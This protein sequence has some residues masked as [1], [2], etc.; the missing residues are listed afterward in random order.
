MDF[1]VPGEAIG[2]AL[3]GILDQKKGNKK[4]HEKKGWKVQGLGGNRGPQQG[5]FGRK[6][7]PGPARPN[8][9][10][11]GGRIEPAEPEPPP[12]HSIGRVGEDAMGR[13]GQFV[14][15]CWLGVLVRR[16]WCGA[17]G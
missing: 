8:P 4:K 14:K 15:P 13:G 5:R 17:G 10:G 9:V 2:K 11:L 12:A 16:W 6:N 7:K 3:G 1:G